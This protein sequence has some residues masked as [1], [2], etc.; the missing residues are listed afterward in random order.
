MRRPVGGSSCESGRAPLFSATQLG[1]NTP[2]AVGGLAGNRVARLWMDLAVRGPF[3]HTGLSSVTAHL[4]E[5]E[6]MSLE[7]WFETSPKGTLHG[8]VVVPESQSSKARR[9]SLLSFRCEN[10]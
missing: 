9:F 5:Q 10:G 3:R 6:P 7:A 8:V 2:A 4:V 1:G